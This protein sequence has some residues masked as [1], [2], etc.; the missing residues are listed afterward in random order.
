[1]EMEIT[2]KAMVWTFTVN[3]LI[4]F[5]V[6]STI[7]SFVS[8]KKTFQF[9]SFFILFITLFILTKT[10]FESGLIQQYANSDFFLFNWYLQVLYNLSYIGFISYLLDLANHDSKLNNLITKAGKIL[11]VSSTLLL[12]FSIFLH[13]Q[14]I[15]INTFLIVFVPCFFMLYFYTLWKITFLR[16]TLKYF[17]LTG[18]ISFVV[19]ASYTLYLSFYSFF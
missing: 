4:I 17:V 19:L 6:I 3:S 5:F 18:S 13:N 10:P 11:F 16:G 15:F 7:I 8:N 1:M 9:Y 12:I 14:N 2:F